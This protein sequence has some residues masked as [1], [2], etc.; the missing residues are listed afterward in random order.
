MDKNSLIIRIC[1]RL[2][3][4]G[5]GAAL[6]QQGKSIEDAHRLVALE[7]KLR[8]DMRK[9]GRRGARWIDPY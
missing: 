2:G 5:E 7:R 6:I 9:A 8:R 3:L 1:A 4:I